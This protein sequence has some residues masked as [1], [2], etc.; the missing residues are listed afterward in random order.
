MTDTIDAASITDDEAG[1]QSL[2]TGDLG[3]ALLA[4]EQALS[5]GDWSDARQLI[6][7]AASGP[8]DA[9]AHSSLFYGAPAILLLL[10]AATADGQDRYGTARATLSGHVR[11][12]V[13][14]RLAAAEQ[15]HRS[16]RHTSFGE[17]DLFYGLTGLSAL[18]RRCMPDSDEYADVLTYAIRLTRQRTDDGDT[19][20]G[21]W[22][23]HDPD[24]T[25]PTPGGHANLG[26]AHGAA[27]LLASLALAAR[28][29]I[30]LDGLLEAID[31][32]ASWFDSWRQDGPLGPWWP[33]WITRDDLRTARPTIGPGRPSWCYGTP[34]IARA[35][36]L[37]A[38]ATGNT[39]RRDVAE[40]ALAAHLSTAHI[41][42][43]ADPGLCHGI[44]GLYQTAYRAAADARTSALADQLHHIAAVL[45]HAEPGHQ[46]HSFLTGTAGY[47]LATRTLTHSPRTRWDT[48]LLIA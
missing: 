20:P 15:R 43:L 47:L 11:H 3:I 34:G 31:D 5:T 39:A 45:T 41:R 48:C 22:V 37:A 6:K 4:V 27:G 19:L 29:G 14:E 30:Q 35:L 21:W 23:D 8:V 16:G 44:A 46:D 24:P 38:I 1:E 36:Q 7:R 28:Q 25:L 33:Q 18:L 13:R 2:I 40:H 32:L 17:Y 10:D 12:L 42:L 9:A 26:M